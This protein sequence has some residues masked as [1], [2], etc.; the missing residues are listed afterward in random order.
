MGKPSNGTERPP[1]RV[2]RARNDLGMMYRLGGGVPQDFAQAFVWFL[3][4]A[5]QG[6][7]AAQYNLGSMFAMGQGAPKD[8]A[9]AYLWFS[10]A[11]ANASDD[12]TRQQAVKNLGLVAA[13]MTPAEIAEAKLRVEAWAPK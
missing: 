9:Q 2:P 8:H 1:S 7:A 11:A 4:A 12:E 5:D 6:A 13:E 10:L 3:M